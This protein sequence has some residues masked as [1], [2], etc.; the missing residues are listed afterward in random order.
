MSRGIIG[1]GRGI[2][3]D[4]RGGGRGY[5]FLALLLALLFWAMSGVVFGYII[6]YDLVFWVRRI[7]YFSVLLRGNYAVYVSLNV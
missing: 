1:R 3:M 6:L 7:R 2:I 4:G 5:W